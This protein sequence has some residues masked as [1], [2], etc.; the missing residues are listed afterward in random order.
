M[1]DGDFFY[2]M[3]YLEGKTL[4]QRLDTDNAMKPDIAV[5][6]IRQICNGLEEAQPREE[7]GASDPCVELPSGTGK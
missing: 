4:A 7:A 3:E 6:V 5:D 1:A 2:V